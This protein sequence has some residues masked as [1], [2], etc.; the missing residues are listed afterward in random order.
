LNNPAT[1]GY[2][3]AP[4][5]YWQGAGG[6][7]TGTTTGV[8]LATLSAGSGTTRTGTPL[9]P[10]LGVT[11]TARPTLSSPTRG[12]QPG[13][14]T[15][16]IATRSGNFPGVPANTNSVNSTAV[17]AS[18]NVRVAAP[19]AAAPVSAGVSRGAPAGRR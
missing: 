9:L 2:Y 12:M 19:V 6:A 1:I 17:G 16:S 18:N 8:P 15:A 10:R 14:P 13:S 4:G 7:R 3:Y 11:S 5:Y